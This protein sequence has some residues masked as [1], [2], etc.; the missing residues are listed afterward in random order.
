MLTGVPVSAGIVPF[1][2][3][4]LLDLTLKHCGIQIQGVPLRAQR[5]PCICHSVIGSK[6]RWISPI[7]NFRNRLQIVSAVGKRVGGGVIPNG[8][9]A[10]GSIWFGE[11][12]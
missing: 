11:V 3:S 9:V 6:K 1:Q 2:G 10:V 4:F 5:R 12:Q 7:P 8:R